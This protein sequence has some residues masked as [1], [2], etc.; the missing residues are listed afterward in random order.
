MLFHVCVHHPCSV[1]LDVYSVLCLFYLTTRVCICHS[2]HGPLR[3]CLRARLFRASLLLLL[4]LCSFLLYL[5]RQLGEFKTKIKKTKFRYQFGSSNTTKERKEKKN[6]TLLSNNQNEKKDNFRFTLTGVLQP[7]RL[8]LESV[9]P[10]NQAK[11][12]KIGHFQT[13]QV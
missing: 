13:F 11:S 9:S 5:A 6:K 12:G 4:H 7:L 10:L 3:E 2:F 8:V 1:F